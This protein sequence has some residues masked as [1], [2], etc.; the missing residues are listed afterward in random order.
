[1]ENIFITARFDDDLFDSYLAKS[2]TKLK[3]RCVNVSDKEG[4]DE[5][6]S[7]SNKY[8]ICVAILKEQNILKN[9]LIVLLTKSDT[10]IIDPIA[11]EKI[12]HIFTEMPNVGVVG[13]MGVKE[14]NS[15]AQLYHFNNKPVNGIIYS[16][17]GEADNGEHVQYS[18]NGFYDDV[19]AI[20]DSIIAVR[21]ELFVNNTI[22]FDNDV[23]SGFGIE[24]SIKAIK[25][26]YGVVVADILVVSNDRNTPTFGDVDKIISNIDADAEY[27]IS[28]EQFK[29]NTDFIVDIDL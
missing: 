11:T 29:I 7:I 16:I 4:C 17:D 10:I 1:M 26:G 9:D 2:L 21:G 23:N 12:E 22:S 25:K 14:L 6:K 24:A 8:N 13:V 18:Q 28:K 19:V 3:T 5:I 27:P 15:D 20:D